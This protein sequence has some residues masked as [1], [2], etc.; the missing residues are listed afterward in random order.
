MARYLFLRSQRPVG[1]SV[2]RRCL[3]PATAAR[4]RLRPPPRPSTV[5][6]TVNEVEASEQVQLIAEG[7]VGTLAVSTSEL[8]RD[9]SRPDW[10]R[11][12]PGQRQAGRW[13]GS[14][15]A[16]GGGTETNVSTDPA[17]QRHG[18]L[19]TLDGYAPRRI[20]MTRLRA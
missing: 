19:E 9:A 3:W 16:Y 11:A 14:F 17:S 1:S 12:P 5:P 20:A 18:I 7:A 8:S 6:R 15:A 2:P 4:L 10:R 13:G